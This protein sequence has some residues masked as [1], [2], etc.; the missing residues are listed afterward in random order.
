MYRGNYL[1]VVARAKNN[2]QGKIGLATVLDE[3]GK[4]NKNLG[5]EILSLLEVKG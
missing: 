1:A 2:F 5:I 4:L 3:N